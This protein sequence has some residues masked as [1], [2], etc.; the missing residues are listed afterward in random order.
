MKLGNLNF[1]TQFNNKNE[2]FNLKIQKNHKIKKN[3]NGHF[4][5]ANLH[6]MLN[7][8]ANAKNGQN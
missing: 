4:N 8:N 6:K 5:N 2:I 3:R 7:K 1:N